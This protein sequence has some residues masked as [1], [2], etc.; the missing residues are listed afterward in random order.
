VRLQLSIFNL[1]NTRASS[2][3]YLYT[4]RL[5]GEPPEGVTGFQA[6]PL[7]PISGV[8]KVTVNF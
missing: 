8:L 4:S 7:E 2:A 5:P 3:A 1:L 6:H